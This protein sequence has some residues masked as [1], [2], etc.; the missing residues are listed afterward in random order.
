MKTF[1]KFFIVFVLVLGSI[2]G[3][4]WM[5]Y[6]NMT[7]QK[8]AFAYVN[9]FLNSADKS[10]TVSKFKSVNTSLDGIYDQHLNT[11][12]KLDTITQTLNT[13]MICSLD[14]DVDNN[15]IIR[16]F[17]KA[18]ESQYT[19]NEYAQEFE[20]KKN[21]P[22]FDKTQGGNDV[23][24]KFTA[25]IL[26]YSAAVRYMN[27]EIEECMIVDHSADI[28]FELIELYCLAVKDG[29]SDVDNVDMSNVNLLHERFDIKH[30]LVT[31]TSDPDMPLLSKYNNYFISAFDNIQNK[32]QFASELASKYASVNV[33]TPTS[34]DEDKAVYYLKEILG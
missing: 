11:I 21:N 8:D 13:Y 19:L 10:A 24:A 20:D 4:C 16:K 14:Y 26:D 27:A 12:S 1:L 32:A 31:S 33:V 25:Y 9:S 34:S 23:F 29:Y 30:G 7:E 6:A 2:G 28:K 17:E 18:Q 22:L 5:F 15:S 3:T